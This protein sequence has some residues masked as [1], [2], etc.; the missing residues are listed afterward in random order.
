MHYTML[1]LK[2]PIDVSLALN[3]DSM[4]KKTT[5]LGNAL[6]KGYV[7]K[8]LLENILTKQKIKILTK[9]LFVI[10]IHKFYSVVILSVSL[11]KLSVII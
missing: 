1:Q 4:P 10:S 6:L 8:R 9:E 3:K 2:R 11:T 7:N 5:G